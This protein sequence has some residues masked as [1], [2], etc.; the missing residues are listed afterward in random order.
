MFDL[1]TGK[2]THTPYTPLVPMIVSTVTQLTIVGLVIVIPWL[3]VTD[4]LPVPSTMTAFV[5]APPLA[6]PPPPPPPA[7]SA[8][9]VRPPEVNPA[10]TTGMVAPIEAPSEIVAEAPAVDYGEEG[11]PGG[12]EGGI[13]TG[14]V[15]GIVGG[16]PA[17]PPPP[18]PP[19]RPTGPV[20]V[21]GEIK[22]PALVHR[23]EPVYP[24]LAVRAGIEGIVILEAT[25][26][27]EGRV[28]DLKVL[29]SH[30]LLEQAAIDAVRQWRY[31]P[32]LLNGKPERF[33]L[34]VVVT[35]RLQP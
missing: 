8:V 10:A 4:Q 18:P 11:I 26:D 2:A 16:V 32:V 9:R 14:L 1:I 24:A 13:P 5:V 33:I 21:G 28:E 31:S 12:L 25:V 7:L 20:R 27:R 23:V 19:P 6:P 3:Y 29:R 34:T 17:P 22:D 15:G 35:F 30:P